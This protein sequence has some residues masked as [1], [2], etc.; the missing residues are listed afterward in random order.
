MQSYDKDRHKLLKREQSS[1][2][3]VKADASIS[4]SVSSPI[5]TTKSYKNQESNASLFSM[6]GVRKIDFL[7]DDKT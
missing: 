2:L 4:V 3:T 1:N 6:Q 5:E 7:K